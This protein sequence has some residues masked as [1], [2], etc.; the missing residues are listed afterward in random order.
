MM[1][2]TITDLQP[3]GH[4]YEHDE[5]SSYD[6]PT[7][8]LPMIKVFRSVLCKSDAVVNLPN[9]QSLAVYLDSSDQM[10]HIGLLRHLT[11]LHILLR[12]G[13]IHSLKSI[14]HLPVCLKKLAVRSC[15]NRNDRLSSVISLTLN[16]GLQQLDLYEVPGYPQVTT[17]ALSGDKH[18]PYSLRML[19]FFA[20]PFH[21]NE[22]TN[23]AM[24]VDLL[25]YAHRRAHQIV[26]TSDRPDVPFSCDIRREHYIRADHATE[27]S[28]EN[29]ASF[30]GVEDY[31]R[32]W[33]WKMYYDGK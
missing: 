4:R 13:N 26:S 17:F 9:V 11:A 12:P 18:L 8:A 14:E 24:R 10:T 2:T 21:G 22:T 27:F 20:C 19:N 15:S 7:V 23:P 1:P 32:M 31:N 16:E 28:M 33:G 25:Q 6:A 3:S 30:F 5:V 29:H